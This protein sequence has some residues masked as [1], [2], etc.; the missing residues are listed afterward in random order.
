M[1]TK[2]TKGPWEIKNSPFEVINMDHKNYLPYEISS[3]CQ[4]IA[5]FYELDAD[6]HLIATAPDMYRAIESLIDELNYAIDEINT[7][8]DIHHTDNMTPADHWDKESLHNAQILL[9]KARGEIK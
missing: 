5:A 7:M 2:F 4:I 1:E 8:R 9:A 3:G 6:T